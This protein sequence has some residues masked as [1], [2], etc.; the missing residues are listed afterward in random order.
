[1]FG[2]AFSFLIQVEFVNQTQVENSRF[3]LEPSE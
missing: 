3:F 1:M 2:L